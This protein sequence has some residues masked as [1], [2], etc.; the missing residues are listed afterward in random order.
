MIK[1]FASIKLAIGLITVLALASVFATLYP[2]A[3][4]FNSFWFRGLL[5]LFCFNLLL[6]TF[7][8]LPGVFKRIKQVPPQLQAENS[9]VTSF[10]V[11]ELIEYKTGLKEYLRS[12]GFK[13]KEETQEG[14]TNILAQAGRLSLIAPHLLHIALIVVL[15]GGFLSSF[16]IEGRV[17]CFVGERQRVPAEFAALE[18]EVND[19]QTRYDQ[20]GAIDNWVTDFNIY[21][22]GRQTVS[23]QTKVNA[24][25]KYKGIVFY[26][27]SYGYQHIIELKGPEAGTYRVPDGQIFQ[28]ENQLVNLNYSPE[29]AVLK[30]FAGHEIVKTLLL[31]EHS[32][33]AFSDDASLKY[34]QLQPFTV[35]GLKKD[36]GTKVVMTGFLLMTIASLFFWTGRYREV[37]ITIQEKENQV[38]LDVFSKIKG[39]REE[40]LNNLVKGVG[41]D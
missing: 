22:D 7:K 13:I 5:I 10:K 38:Y 32:E 11:A 12:R 27:K 9:R 25:F 36:P 33:I 19:F 1:F 14:N 8:S 26:Q 15:L 28:L 17:S 37:R 20:E 41:A 34:I 2:Q 21:L 18:I 31:K 23:G 35:L 30:Y 39:F 4:V 40:I 29:G 16:R 3:D 24:P 6:C